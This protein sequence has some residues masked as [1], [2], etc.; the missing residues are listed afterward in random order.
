M[1]RLICLAALAAFALALAACTSV[2][3]DDTVTLHTAVGGANINSAT[4]LSLGYGQAQG[5][6]VPTRSADGKSLLVA[7]DACGKTQQPSSYATLAGQASASATGSAVAGP[8]AAV[9]ISN[10]SATGEAARYLALGAPGAAPT[11]EAITATNDCSKSIPE[12][13]SATAK[14]GAP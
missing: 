11:P 9:A 3:K 7:Q 2:L 14:T 6:F 10:V 5:H 4:G 8:Q 1:N 13:A 12:P